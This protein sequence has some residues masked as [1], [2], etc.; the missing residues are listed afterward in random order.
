MMGLISQEFFNR[1]GNRI[2]AFW[3]QPS[4]LSSSKEDG[5]LLNDHTGTVRPS[6]S[7]QPQ[8]SQSPFPLWPCPLLS[9]SFW[10]QLFVQVPKDPV[11]IRVR[12]IPPFLKSCSRKGGSFF[13]HSYSLPQGKAQQGE[14]RLLC[15]PNP[16][17]PC[18]KHLPPRLAV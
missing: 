1:V 5:C 18:T 10:P 7:S 9:Q 14:K 13:S 8:K 16:S 3:L 2:Q 12:L 6:S 15:V 4:G 11:S 17:L